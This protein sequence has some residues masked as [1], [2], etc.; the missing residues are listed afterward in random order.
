MSTSNQTGDLADNF[1]QLIATDDLPGL[2]PE[3]RSSVDQASE[4]NAKIRDWAKEHHL[5]SEL[6]DLLRSAALLWHD[7]LDASHSVSQSIPSATG[8]FLHGIMH[9]RE[10]DYGNAKYWFHRVGNHGAYEAIYSN[11]KEKVDNGGL[12]PE[13]AYLVRSGSWDPFGFVDAVSRGTADQTNSDL[14]A[15]LKHI[16]EIEFQSLIRSFFS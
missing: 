15:E 4:L 1:L 14:V 13:F 2:G 11:V 8:S 16:Q 10:P 6:I 9:R 7:H 3:V 12:S 5:D